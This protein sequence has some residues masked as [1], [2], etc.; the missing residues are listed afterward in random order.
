MIVSTKLW[1]WSAVWIERVS[2]APGCPMT[3]FCSADPWLVLVMVFCTSAWPGHCSLRFEGKMCLFKPLLTSDLSEERWHSVPACGLPGMSSGMGAETLQDI[4]LLSMGLQP[5]PKHTHILF[6]M[7]SGTHWRTQS[8]A[9]MKL[10]RNV[11]VT[12]ACQ[13]SRPWFLLELQNL[14]STATRLNELT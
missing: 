6:L 10:K 4:W 7:H 2:A 5:A 12:R 3:S 11:S 1:P 14:I 8:S 9:L 13:N